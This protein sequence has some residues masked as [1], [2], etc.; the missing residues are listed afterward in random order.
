MT[1]NILQQDPPKKYKVTQEALSDFA[2]TIEAK[3]NL[4]PKELLQKFP[5]FNNDS[6]ALQAA[7][8]YH[9]TS[10]SGKYKTAEELN[11]KFPEFEFTDI[12][13]KSGGEPVGKTSPIGGGIANAFGFEKFGTAATPSGEIVNKS[14]PKTSLD[15][16]VALEETKGNAPLPQPKKSKDIIST[17]LLQPKET[18]F[19]LNRTMAPVNLDDAPF[20]EKRDEENRTG[21]MRN[22]LLS[23]V[24]KMIAGASDNVMNLMTSVLPDAVVGD[25]KQN[26][27]KQYR[28]E[29]A[30]ITRDFIKDKLGDETVTNEQDKQYNDE[31][32]TSIVGGL[33]EQVVPMLA[34]KATKLIAMVSSAQD[35]ALESINNTEVGKA[36]PESTK[37]IFSMSVGVA[38]GALEKFGFDKIF[39]KQSSALSRK[40]AGKVM[41][42]LLEKSDAPVTRELYEQALEA[43]MKT[44]KQQLINTTSKLGKASAVEG[45]TETFQEGATVF[46]EA[47]VNKATGQDAFEPKSW[48]QQLGRVL[49]AGAQGAVGGIILGG[50]SI[51]LSKSGNYI[52]EKAMEAK[53]IEDIQ[54]LKDD[55]ALSFENGLLEEGEAIQLDQLIDD[56]ARLN[57]KIP[58]DAPNRKQAADKI[59]E[60]EDIENDIAQKTA[61]IQQMDVAFQQ[62]AMQEVDLLRQR[63]EEINQEILSPTPEPSAP[64]VEGT[65]E[66]ISTPIELEPTLSKGNELG[67]EGEVKSMDVADRFDTPVKIDDIGEGYVL[68]RGSK[69][70][71]P[72]GF[73]SLDKSGAEGYAGDG[74]KVT[75]SVI[76]KGA[77]VLKLVDGDTDN[78]KDNEDGINEFYKI[79]GESERAKG[80]EW[81]EGEMPSDITTRLWDNPKAVKK[82]KDAGIDVVIGNTID[83][84]D[85]FVVNENAVTK[86][87]SE[88]PNQVTTPERSVANA[89]KS[90]NQSSL[91]KENDKVT[92][93]PQVKGGLERTMIFNEGEWKQEVGDNKTKVSAKVQEQAME[94]FSPKADSPVAK[95]FSDSPE[96]SKVGTP[97]EYSEYVGNI[98][99]DSK[100][101]YI[102]YHGTDQQFDDFNTVRP[103]GMY[104]ASFTTDLKTAENYTSKNGTGKERRVVAA[105]L[106]IKNPKAVNYEEAS[107]IKEKPTEY[108]AYIDATNDGLNH[109]EYVVFDSKQIHILGSKKDVENFK[110]WKSEND[111]KLTEQTTDPIPTETSKPKG[112]GDKKPVP[113]DTKGTVVGDAKVADAVL[114]EE[115]IK[116]FNEKADKVA[117]DLIDFLTPKTTKGATTKGVTIADVVKGANE[118]IKATYAAS[119]NIKEAVEAGIKHFK[120][121]WDSKEYGELPEAALREKLTNQMLAEESLG[122]GKKQLND[123]GILSHLESATN[124]PN[125]AKEGFR[126]KGLKYEVQSSKEA[127]AVGKSMIDEF[128]MDEAILLAEANKF[129]GGV[130]S[131]IFAESLNRLFDQ[132]SKATT[133]ESKL[134]AAKKFA[135]VGIRYDEFS[136]GHFTDRILL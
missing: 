10:K 48:G 2:A 86:A 64:I 108:D 9:E 126:E 43:Y 46:A 21:Y 119:L 58:K 51:P 92:L 74:G 116:K 135:E 88:K 101:K 12:K 134:E 72:N 23:G 24:G 63:A 129:K 17:P 123:K 112:Q 35:N 47:I 65:P 83:G 33:A 31:F 44:A 11:A 15:P 99:P 89:A 26:V 7:F 109:D 98:F 100:V 55:L 121:N 110:K 61:D 57:A 136:R 36:L 128:G 107:F 60:R 87:N 34:P 19:D 78:Y 38:Q 3:P 75:S 25:S 90:E 133:P 96:L 124:V 37:S 118:V 76:N 122:A 102:V 93:P 120:D 68:H 77:K 13:K 130:N 115:R 56:Y 16:L 132:E 97:D 111:T 6:N 20:L 41:A 62:E 113:S 73:N 14:R 125:S 85:A 59:L 67:V 91:P 70:D 106:D 94:A 32:L 4:T 104:G 49:K 79:I 28:E 82:L 5:E 105:V 84:V 80:S 95:V 1:E 50:V 18:G 69:T 22:K 114:K 53:S 29:T 117:N 66:T 27:M 52:S 45:F 131:A 40:I 30:P 54:A 42:D 81:A 103:N 71:T 8:D 127:E 39:G